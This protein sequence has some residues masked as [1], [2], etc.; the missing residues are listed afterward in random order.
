M[1]IVLEVCVDSF[2]SAAAAQAGGA[3]RLEVCSALQLGGTTPNF[4]LLEQC[5]GELD[6]PVMMMIRPHDGGFVYD[7]HHVDTM[8]ADIRVARSLGVRGIV[9]GALT[10]QRNLDRET[11]RRLL[12]AAEDLET[13]FHRAFDLV[14]D[15]EGTLHELESL[16]FHRVLTSGQQSTAMA[17]A[18]LIAVLTQQ[19]ASL[20]VLAGA[21][22]DASNVRRL[23]E[24]T[25][26]QE[27]HAS[28][29][30]PAGDGQSSGTIEFG[31][32]RRV[33][34]AAGVR[35]IRAALA[36]HDESAI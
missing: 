35:A 29:S 18:E 12:D 1:S 10:P 5:V 9:F 22:I 32:Q 36:G 25:G 17:G 11:C 33:T 8:L 6:L 7:S 31:S 14:P 30:V 27:V 4:G 2:A 26:V 21:G 20:Q 15:P 16:G 34:S 13:T 24:R 23:V 28:A 3:D 19:A